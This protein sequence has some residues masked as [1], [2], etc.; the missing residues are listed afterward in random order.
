MGAELLA[1][2]C[3]VDDGQVAF[4]LRIGFQPTGETDSNEEVLLSL[5]IQPAG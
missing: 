3:P 5:S 4:H 2:S 1:T